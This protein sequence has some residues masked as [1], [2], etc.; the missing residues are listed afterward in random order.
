MSGH[1]TPETGQS[2][3]GRH[4]GELKKGERARVTGVDERGVVTT[5]PEGELERRMIEMGLVE[6]SHVEVLHEAF[7]GRDPIAIRVNEHTLALR[8]AEA[9]AVLVA[10]AA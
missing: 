9:R 3:G 8:R 7:P 10:P 2:H 4:L 5:L 6:G 1:P